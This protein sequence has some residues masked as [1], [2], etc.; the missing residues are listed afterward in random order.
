MIEAQIAKAES[1]AAQAGIV[2]VFVGLGNSARKLCFPV[3]TC[4]ISY[5]DLPPTQR[6]TVAF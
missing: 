4:P 1:F 3:L 6:A 5:R 2:G